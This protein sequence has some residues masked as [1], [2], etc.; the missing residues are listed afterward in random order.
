MKL[1]PGYVAG[2]GVV[3]G[4]A[5]G[6][7]GER[8]LKSLG[9][10]KGKGLGKDEQGMKDAIEVKKKEDTIGV[11]GVILVSWW[12]SGSDTEFVCPCVGWRWSCDGLEGCL[13]GGC[14]Q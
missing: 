2:E 8:M 9:W 12:L 11:R 4:T 1:P 3:Q 7:F 10:E 14:V 5:Y 6:G 13:V